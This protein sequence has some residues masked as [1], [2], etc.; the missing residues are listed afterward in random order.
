[1]T[2]YKNGKIY[3]IEC[4]ETNRIY[5]GSTCQPTVAG[6]LRGH[7]QH[8]KQYEKGNKLRYLSSF[9]ILETGNYKCLLVC[10]YPCNTKDELTAKEAEYI[11]QYRNDDM[12]ECVNINIPGRT[13]TEYYEDNK[14]RILERY[15]QYYEDNKGM[16]L[17]QN[18]QYRIDNRDRLLEYK[19]QYRAEN[20]EKIAEYAKQHRQ[21]E[22]YI[23]THACQCG[24]KS[25]MQNKARHEKTKKHM[26]WEATQ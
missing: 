13:S 8:K 20:K 6:R 19:K 23:T 22:K 1:M 5:I 21:K 17:E 12:Y 16:V 24:G 3:K 11:K 4:Q 14:D 18:K 9:I 26:K 25:T 7:V 10:N 15:K 2:D